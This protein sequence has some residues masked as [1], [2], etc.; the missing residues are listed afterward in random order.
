MPFRGFAV[1]SVC[2]AAFRTYGYVMMSPFIALTIAIFT[3]T[4][5]RA[6]GQVFHSVSQR[7][8]G[9][10]CAAFPYVLRTSISVAKPKTKSGVIQLRLLQWSEVI[11]WSEVK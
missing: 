1:G 4:Y 9:I 7:R 6:G 5:G 8:H 11:Q 10:K 2:V 3:W